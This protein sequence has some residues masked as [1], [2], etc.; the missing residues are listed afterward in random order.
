MEIYLPTNFSAVFH[1]SSGIVDGYSTDE[2]DS[3]SDE[4]VNKI[5]WADD[6]D[7]SLDDEDLQNKV[8]DFNKLQMVRIKKL[9]GIFILL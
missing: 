9:E 1:A 4:D 3:D 2:Q 7:E 5:T 8:E 6:G